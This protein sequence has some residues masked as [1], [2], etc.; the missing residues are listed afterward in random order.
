MAR[1]YGYDRLGTKVIKEYYRSG[2]SD[3]DFLAKKTKV[4]KKKVKKTIDTEK[5]VYGSG[6]N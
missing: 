4:S 2:V 6:W 1:N 3:I 5:I